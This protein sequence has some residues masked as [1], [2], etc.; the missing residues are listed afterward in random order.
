M[1]KTA[2]QK[3][4]GFFYFWGKPLAVRGAVRCGTGGRAMLAPTAFPVIARSAATRQS[5]SWPPLGGGSARRA[6]G[7][8][9]KSFSLPPSPAVTPPSSEGG[10]RWQR[11]ATA[12]GPRND[13]EFTMLLPVWEDCAAADT[14]RWVFQYQG[15]RLPAGGLPADQRCGRGKNGFRRHPPGSGSGNGGLLR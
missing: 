12:R 13:R 5:A 11:I 10:F 4:G 8:R 1:L 7:E 6:V 14:G 9:T 15:M 3:Q 2:L